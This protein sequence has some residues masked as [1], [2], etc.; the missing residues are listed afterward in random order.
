MPLRGRKRLRWSRGWAWAGL[1]W[2]WAGLGWGVG[3]AGV[4]VGNPGTR[5]LR[6]SGRPKTRPQSHPLK[7]GKRSGTAAP[8]GP[9]THRKRNRLGA[10]NDAS[11][12]SRKK[13]LAERRN[14]GKAHTKAWV[15]WLGCAGLSWAG[16]AGLGWRLV[17]LWQGLGRPG[18]GWAGWPGLG[19]GWAGLGCGLGWGQ[20]RQ[21]RYSAASNLRKTQNEAP[22][23]P[24][25]NRET[26]R[27]GGPKRTKNGPKTMLFRGRKRPV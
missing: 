21:P 16:L 2:A 23:P 12:S 6:T 9:K 24:P 1:G 19:L 7:T 13:P 14:F 18:L 15:D 11:E 25:Q 5:R 26:Q 4:N 10:E 20:R 8:N 22:E 3:W 27:H 17:E